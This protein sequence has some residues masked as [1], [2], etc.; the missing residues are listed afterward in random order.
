MN[1]PGNRSSAVRRRVGSVRSWLLRERQAPA[2]DRF[3]RRGA[4][5]LVLAVLAFLAGSSLPEFPVADDAPKYPGER[6]LVVVG[7]ARLAVPGP[8]GAAPLMLV[9]TAWL[10]ARSQP[11]SSSF[12]AAICEASDRVLPIPPIAN[13]PFRREGAVFVP[14]AFPAIPM[15]PFFPPS[16]FRLHT[17]G[18]SRAALAPEQT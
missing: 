2:F 10:E 17:G 13:L 16:G 5:L 9:Q 14:S 8:A 18:P 4:G 12:D 7:V 6:C 3:V 15:R 11:D 1:A